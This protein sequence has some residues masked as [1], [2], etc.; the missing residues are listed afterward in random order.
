MAPRS[1][2]C[3]GSGAKDPRAFAAAWA[4][5]R[6]ARAT[7]PPRRLP[8]RWL[9]VG[10]LAFVVLLAAIV[11]AGLLASSSG[12]SSVPDAVPAQVEPTKLAFRQQM[13]GTSIAGAQRHAAQDLAAAGAHDDPRP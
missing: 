7:A 6:R 13:V 8:L 5:E 9:L 11:A 3:S 4:T 10:V 2:R 1:R 12:G